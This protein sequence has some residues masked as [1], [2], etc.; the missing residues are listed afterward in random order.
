MDPAKYDIFERAVLK[1]GLPTLLVFAGLLFFAGWLPSPLTRVET[2]LANHQQTTEF[3]LIEKQ[4]QTHLL[5]K[6][7]FSLSKNPV[8]DCLDNAMAVDSAPKGPPMDALKAV[9]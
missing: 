4:K 8:V 7:C 6:I 2:A 1:L 9:R 5:R 3:V